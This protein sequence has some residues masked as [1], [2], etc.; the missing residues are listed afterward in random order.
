MN[1]NI[2]DFIVAVFGFDEKKTAVEIHRRV[3]GST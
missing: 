3:L 2:N 1:L